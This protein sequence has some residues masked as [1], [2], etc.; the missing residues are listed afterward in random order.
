MAFPNA[1]PGQ[2]RVGFIG[3]GV[4]GAPLASHVLNAG[5]PLTVFNRT[6][7]KAEKLLA[8]GA[9]WAETPADVARNSDVVCAIVG[10]P[11]D[12]RIVFLGPDG[13]LAARKAV[14]SLSI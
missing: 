14:P 13:I 1:T 8:A 6:K 5:Y 9:A 4:M 10:L 2:T 3:T 12:V 11:S 7:S